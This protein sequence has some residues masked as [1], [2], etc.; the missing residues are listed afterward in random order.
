MTEASF[1]SD[2]GLYATPLTTLATQMV[3]LFADSSEA[4]FM[5]NDDGLVTEEELTTA[6]KIAGDRVKSTLGFGIGD[7]VNI[8]LTPTLIDASTVSSEAQLAAAA[9]RSAVE[10]M[11]AV[12]YQILAAAG[13]SGFTTDNVLS[14]L[15]ADLADGEIDAFADGVAVSS[16]NAAS[17][18]LFDQDPATLPIPG[19][20]SGR[21]VG[22]VK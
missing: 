8:F 17:L 12:I 19:D 18:N 6:A 21:T 9:Y 13:D 14:D 1:E 16:Y 22:D 4:P 2:G 10:G 5:G 3:I 11:S 7:D 15:A 20:E